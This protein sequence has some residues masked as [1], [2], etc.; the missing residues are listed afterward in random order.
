[1]PYP[2][3]KN[4]TKLLKKRNKALERSLFTLLS[5]FIY[6]LGNSLPLSGIDQQDLKKSLL[7]AENRNAFTQVLS[8]Y[9]NGGSTL[10]SPFSLGIIPYINASIII[11]ILTVLIPYFEKLQSEEG[12]LGKNK[13]LLYK[14]L[15]SILLAIFQAYFLIRYI[16]NYLYDTR[17]FTFFF[18]ILQLVAGTIIVIWLT[19]TMDKQ[20]LANG[21][22]ILIVTNIITSLLAKL[23][24]FPKRINPFEILF[25]GFMCLLICIYQ[26]TKIKIPI[27]SAR[28][29]V[30]FQDS[31]IRELVRKD[32]DLNRNKAS[33]LLIKLNQPGIF[34]IIAVTNIIGFFPFLLGSSNLVFYYTLYCFLIIVF[35]YFYTII[36]WDPEKISNEL[37]KASVSV[38]ELP[39]GEKTKNYL[40][41]L[42]RSSSILGGLSL[43]AIIVLYETIKQLFKSTILNYLNISSLIIVVGVAYEIQKSA[44][45]LAKMT[46]KD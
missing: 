37:R 3:F 27:T 15:L 30:Y 19:T 45:S 6:R 35:N 32:Q 33:S 7:L 14:K 17:L 46:I 39:P 5:V 43:C 20:G 2:L 12:S 22:S 36:F 1:M 23:A 44:R 21:T 34:P 41:T 4:Q 25:L 42:V 28:Q 13:L 10:L 8:M 26:T 40:N 9:S 16:K 24:S 18:L 29:L 38:M 11:D 31:Q